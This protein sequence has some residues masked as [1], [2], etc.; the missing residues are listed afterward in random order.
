ME[1]RRGAPLLVQ[2]GTPSTRMSTN[3]AKVIRL[4]D[5][6]K[7]PQPICSRLSGDCRRQPIRSEF[8]LAGYG[9]VP[10]DAFVTG[11]V[12]PA[13]APVCRG[14]VAFNRSASRPVTGLRDGIEI[15]PCAVS[16]FGVQ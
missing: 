14:S 3:S 2:R 11:C 1:L 13:M 15:T 4:S 7:A 9:Y 10:D 12:H 5:A 8:G 6:D 16:V